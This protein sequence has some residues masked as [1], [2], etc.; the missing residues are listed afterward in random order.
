LSAEP[1]HIWIVFKPGEHSTEDPLKC[2]IAQKLNEDPDIWWAFVTKDEIR[3]SRSS[4]YQRYTYEVPRPAKEFIE[5]LKKYGAADPFLLVL[6]DKMLIEV[7]NCGG[8][9]SRMDYYYFG[10][11]WWLPQ[12]KGRTR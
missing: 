10:R 9:P 5:H 1:L 6:T 4:T 8:Q 11:R 2:P 3:F 7:H 12:L